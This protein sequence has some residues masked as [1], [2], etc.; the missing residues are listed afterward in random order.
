MAGLTY[1]FAR[2]PSPTVE[3]TGRTHERAS[4]GG[5]YNYDVT[6]D[7]DTE[8]AASFDA[9]ALQL[10][11]AREAEERLSIAGG[12][13]DGDGD[14]DDMDRGMFFDPTSTHGG[15]GGGEGQGEDDEF[16]CGPLI[17]DDSPEAQ[18]FCAICDRQVVEQKSNAVRFTTPLTI[19]AAKKGIAPLKQARWAIDIY[20]KNERHLI[21]GEPEWTFQSAVRHFRKLHNNAT[22]EEAQLDNLNKLVAYQ[23]ECEKHIVKRKRTTGEFAGFNNGPLQCILSISKLI[24]RMKR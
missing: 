19:F 13:D 7:E 24:H 1:S 21:D 16:V 20:N 17:D 23:A 14:G 6:E 4:G 11:E 9:K 12:D 2:N 18:E 3:Y 8:D 5:R 15:G 10:E 22:V